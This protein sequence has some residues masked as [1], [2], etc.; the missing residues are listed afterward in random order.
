MLSP[1]SE[2]LLEHGWTKLL[3]VLYPS[4]VQEGKE[5]DHT[6]QNVLF[7]KDLQLECS[8]TSYQ[9]DL[10][11]FLGHV[12]ID[13][14]SHYQ[15]ILHHS[16]RVSLLIVS[17]VV[18]TLNGFKEEYTT[19]SGTKYIVVKWS[20]QDSLSSHDAMIDYYRIYQV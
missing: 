16:C 17:E 4:Q 3:Y 6:Y 14:Y 1:F 11:L 5:G 15:T 8:S 10:S 13:T 7:L 20:C 19:K 2:V 18:H 9:K 12:Y